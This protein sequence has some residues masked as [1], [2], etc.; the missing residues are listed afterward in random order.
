[1]AFWDASAIVPLCCRQPASSLIRRLLRNHPRITVWWRTP[2]EVRSALARLTREGAISA[3]AA[4]EPRKRLDL[5][6][7]SWSEMLPT[8]RVRSLAEKAT[9]GYNL[10]AQDAFQLAAALVWCNENPR[11]WPFICL[12]VRLVQ[13]AEQAGFSRP[14][15]K[16]P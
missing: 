2:V 14:I 16:L 8:Q 10:R 15:S 1:M 12:N 9:E 11:K 7:Q 13:A 3:R 5:L 4:A 6:R